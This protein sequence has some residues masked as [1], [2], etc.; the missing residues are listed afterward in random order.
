MCTVDGEGRL[1]PVDMTEYLQLFI[2]E[3]QEHLQ[4]LNEN[5]LALE[6]QPKDLAIVQTIFRSAHTLKGMA[7]AMHFNGMAHLTHE[8]ESS[9]DELRSGH[10][11]VSEAVLNVLFESLDVL[12]R[13]LDQIVA[14]G[15]DE[16]IHADEAVAHI[17]ALTVSER[18]GIGEAK[19]PLDAAIETAIQRE[20]ESDHHVFSVEV[21]IAPDSPMQSVRGFMVKRAY[22][23][24]GEIL[25][26]EPADPA[27][28]EFQGSLRLIVVSELDESAMRRTGQRISEVE[29]VKVR[30][31]EA[32]SIESTSAVAATAVK[33]PGSATRPAQAKSIRVDVDRLDILMNLYSEFVIDKTRL[34]QLCRTRQDAEL[35]ETVQHLSQVGG[36]L[37]DI[38][39]KIRMIPLET[40]FN[41][42][43]R[44]V[45]DLSKALNKKVNFEVSGADTEID[46]V[47]ADDI[48][49]P[50]VHMLRNSMDHGLES[51]AE[52]TERGKTEAGTIRLSAYHA[53]NHVFIEI[54]D[55]G[56]GID[57]EKVLQKAIQHGLVQ[58]RDAALLTDEQVYTL[59]F[60]S[61]LSTAD[62]VSDIS[63][64]G[65]GLDAVLSK[66]HALG[67][68]VTVR[69]V[70]GQGTTFVIRLPLTVSILS[71]MLVNAGAETFAIPTS[72]ILYMDT[73]QKTAIDT[74]Q[75]KNMWD[76]RGKLI[77]LVYLKD[78]LYVRDVDVTAVV[79]VAVLGKGDKLLALGVDGFVGQQE[80]VLKSLG[81]YL[82]GS[83]EGISGATIL[84]DGQ[85]ALIVDPNSFIH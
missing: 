20:L 64:R 11:H 22:E 67:G 2:E 8:M 74:C 30:P 76:F 21:T 50:L 65:V 60:Q 85:V 12:Q 4:A 14:S 32:A 75:G 7:G 44:M 73:L 70:P 41:R 23:E 45:R 18:D 3:S 81:P 1:T 10:L 80:V 68:E 79:H 35:S 19:P 56:R 5:L 54:E 25:L 52:R 77:P 40:V 29:D 38:I 63:G 13:Q 62:Q 28:D 36:D 51:P 16:G 9:L 47:L 27:S 34:E 69:S 49:D 39:M 37:Q 61:G 83:T 66:I 82:H 59:L 6:K 53:G 78:L 24:I 43:P 55:D 26:S 72:S 33:Q 15:S 17:R 58:V 84:G 31:I 57:R 42:F 48:A 46:R 71:A